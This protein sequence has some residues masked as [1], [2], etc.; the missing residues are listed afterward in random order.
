MATYLKRKRFKQTVIAL[1]ELEGTMH[2][3]SLETATILQVSYSPQLL[4]VEKSRTKGSEM[5]PEVI[6]LV[7]RGN[8][9]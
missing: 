1:T 9:A 7:S 2:A 8:G 5:F 4:L 3:F 6:Q